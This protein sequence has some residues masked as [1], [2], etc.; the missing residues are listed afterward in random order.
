LR[1]RPRNVGV[2]PPSRWQ[3]RLTCPQ[4]GTLRP[5][6]LGLDL[7]PSPPRQLLDPPDDHRGPRRRLQ[8]R[9]CQGAQL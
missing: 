2:V 4:R 6:P 7:P 3:A 5:L 8:P 9:P 1:C